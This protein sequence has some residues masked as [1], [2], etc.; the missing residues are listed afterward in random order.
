[1]NTT[2]RIGSIIGVAALGLYVSV[3]AADATQ[4]YGLLRGR[5]LTTFGFLRL[6]MR[7][8]HAIAIE[9]GSWAIETELGY[10]NTWSLSPQVEQ[11]LI[12]LEPA[13]RRNLGAAEL[14]AI[15]NLPGENYLLDVES[16]QFDLT[17]HYKFSTNW[18]GY[19]I[20]SAVSYQGG[21][22]DGLIENFH[23]A[24]GF[25][26]FGR[27]AARR[28]DVNLIYNL[29][30]TNFTSF[31]SPTDGGMTDPTLGVRYTGLG[32]AKNWK[33]AIEAAVKVPVAGRRLLLSTGR[34][35]YGI[36]ASLQHFGQSHAL[37]LDA[38]AVY[39]AG[40]SDPVPQDS[41]VIPTI[42]VGYER[43]L[44]ERTNLNLQGYISESVYSHKQTDLKELLGEKYQVSIGVR[45]RIEQYL[46]SFAFT[47]NLQNVNNTPDIGFQLGVAY[48]PKR[49]ARSH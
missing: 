19:L 40:A 35:D 47:E 4:Y 42:I 34:T 31:G 5:D 16:A 27:P 28:N 8:A 44:T 25:S 36:Q 9:P 29:K 15:R 7:P 41:Q 26:S 22:L 30:S 10:Q 43:K 20:G 32:L 13:G 33:L 45:H 37:Y 46:I 14:Q 6:D 2:R 17:F 38:A 49:I 11:Y 21:F 24:F 39:Y 48:I 18:A 3:A 1:V 23:D 12:S